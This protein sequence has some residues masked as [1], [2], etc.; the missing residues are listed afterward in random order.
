M[1]TLF[2]NL[3]FK[4]MSSRVIIGVGI[5]G[6]PLS[7]AG[8]TWAFLQWVLGFQDAGWD[9][10]LV[11]EIETKKCINADWKPCSFEQSENRKH[12]EKI[13]QEIGFQE[14]S[15]LWV[16]G[17]LD[18]PEPFKEF[19]KETDLFL[20]ISG[21]F[22]Q[23]IITDTIS[24][25]VYL[26]LDPAFTQ[27]W[28]EV[29]GESMNLDPHTHFFTLGP[30]LETQKARSPQAG[31][32]WKGTFPLVHLPSWNLSSTQGDR[33]TTMTHWYGY[34]AVEYQNQW[35]G[36]KTEEFNQLITLPN[37]TAA[38]LEIASDLSEASEEIHQFRKGGWKMTKASTPNESLKSYHNYI[39]KSRGEL[40]VAKNGYVKSHCGW[41]SDR[42]VC[43]LASGKPA[44]L[45]ETGW[46]ELIPSQAGA[47]AFKNENEA[48]EA[49][50]QIESDYSLHSQEARKLA[51]NYFDS[52]KVISRLLKKL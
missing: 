12:W 13:I 15:A 31:R 51:E 16:D 11:E 20:N 17:I 9:V 8:N 48:I 24:T 14:R 47:L 30:H 39:Q 10:F 1:G 43:Y 34:P 25:R 49:L 4:K 50:N 2:G 35:Y 38:T 37:K 40:S 42:T 26:D 22:K 33:Y 18:Q 29:Y 23:K 21:H 6:Y 27:I 41:L 7:A 52:Q 44:I 5:A 46:S 45:Q 19:L 36:N 32:S 28:N 3:V